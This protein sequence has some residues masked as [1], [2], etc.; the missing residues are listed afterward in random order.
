M[1]ARSSD[2]ASVDDFEL[3]FNASIGYDGE[4]TCEENTLPLFPLVA[5]KLFFQSPPYF[6]IMEY[7][8]KHAVNGAE[9]RINIFGHFRSTLNALESADLTDFADLDVPETARRASPLL[10]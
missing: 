2:E 3:S 1:S 6:S 7:V 9:G 8:Q 10:S 4:W 5:G